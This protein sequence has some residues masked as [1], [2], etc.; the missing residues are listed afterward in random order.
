ML[1]LRKADSISSS[2]MMGSN[3]GSVEDGAAVGPILRVR[4][5][6][7]YKVLNAPATN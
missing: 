3:A 7:L 6:R 4:L 5:R 2:M 1:A